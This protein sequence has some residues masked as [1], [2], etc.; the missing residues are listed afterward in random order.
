M[1]IEI[2]EKKILREIL[3]FNGSLHEKIKEKVTERLVDN[4]VEV[5]EEKYLSSS[6]G[7][8]KEIADAVL[9]E[10]RE[11]QLKTTK[12]ILQK[13]YDGYRWGKKDITILKKLKE[14]LEEDKD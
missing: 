8:E 11:I 5:I 4:M 14:L 13:F 10:V 3:E 2:D 6:W 12:D 9:E 7:R 1:Q